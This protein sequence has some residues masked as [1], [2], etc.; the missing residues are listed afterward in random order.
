MSDFSMALGG[1]SKGQLTW[2]R[3]S[4]GASYL[5]I[6]LS[7]MMS[8]WM[9]ALGVNYKMGF[10]VMLKNSFLM[11]VGTFPQTIFFGAIALVPY[12]LLMIGGSMFLS[13]GVILLVLFGFSYTLLVWLDFAQWVF[14]KFINP[15][16]SGAKVGR[17]IYNR[18]GT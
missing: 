15:K 6:T 1:M 5:F 17:C 8:L 13:F 4:Q 3:I 10:L 11:S 2:L 18:D 16:L 9:I 14:D 7:A 12:V